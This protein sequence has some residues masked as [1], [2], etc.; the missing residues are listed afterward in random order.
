MAAKRSTKSRQSTKIAT[1]LYLSQ[2]GYY[3]Y[4]PNPSQIP[5][6]QLGPPRSSGGP[7]QQQ[8]FH[9]PSPKTLFT[10]IYEYKAQGDDELNLEKGMIIQSLQLIFGNSMSIWRKT[11]TYM[12]KRINKKYRVQHV[13][14]HQGLQ[15]L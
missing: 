10:A 8:M 12:L 13:P 5:T 15:R 2:H 6:H 3:G 9:L 14:V 4:D 7:Q 11:I 1:P